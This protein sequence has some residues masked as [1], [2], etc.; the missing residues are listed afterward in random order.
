MTPE[1]QTWVF[2]VHPEVSFY[3]LNGRQPLKH[4]KHEREGK[5]ERM[6]LSIATY[7]A[8]QNHLGELKRAHVGEDDLLD[9]AVAGLDSRT[10][11]PGR[12]TPAI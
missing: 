3:T 6:R 11:I 2:E 10:R 1:M 7:P 5:D 9:A 8:I 12:Y 4:S